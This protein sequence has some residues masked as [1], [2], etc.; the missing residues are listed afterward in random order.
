MKITIT[1][2]E[3][4]MEVVNAAIADN[5]QDANAFVEEL[6]EKVLDQRKV[7]F[8]RSRLNAGKKFIATNIKR[9]N[10]GYESLEQ[11][12]ITLG[13]S[14]DVDTFGGIRKVY[15]EIYVKSGIALE[16]SAIRLNNVVA[17]AAKA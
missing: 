4:S 5:D 11:A 3:E 1:L 12:Y 9:G 14:N 15:E 16:A 7:Q 17:V 8:A 13:L 6:V 10:K 2:S